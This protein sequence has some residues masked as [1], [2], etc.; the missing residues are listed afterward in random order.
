MVL[1]SFAWIRYQRQV[2]RDTALLMAFDDRA[3]ADIGLSRGEILY[4]VQHGRLPEGSPRA[5]E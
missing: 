5:L 2:R 1:R 4:A 3:L